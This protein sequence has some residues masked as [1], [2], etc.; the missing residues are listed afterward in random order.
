MVIPLNLTPHLSLLTV[1]KIRRKRVDQNN[2]KYKQDLLNDLTN[3]GFNMDSVSTPPPQEL[4]PNMDVNYYNQ[5][6][7]EN[8]KIKKKIVSLRQNLG[9]SNNKLQSQT[10]KNEKLISELKTLRGQ[11]SKRKKESVKLLKAKNTLLKEKIN[12]RT[13]LS[14][15]R[16]FLDEQSKQTCRATT[17][18]EECK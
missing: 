6:N 15:I 13:E 10:I 14:E 1:S 3:F 8:L 9:E 2:S 11:I 4:A 17:F 7:A 12:L 18:N 5:S 16:Q